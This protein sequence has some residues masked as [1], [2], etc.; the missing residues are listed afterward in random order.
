MKYQKFFCQCLPPSSKS[1]AFLLFFMRHTITF[2]NGPPRL[3]ICHQMA[4]HKRT[5]M[6]AHCNLK[7]NTWLCSKQSSFFSFYALPSGGKSKDAVVH[8]AFVMERIGIVYFQPCVSINKI[9]MGNVQLSHY[10]SFG[11]IAIRT[12]N[13]ETL[14]ILS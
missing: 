5:T 1:I 10:S 2:N 13:F 3:S 4:V 14:S 8:Y 12:L 6:P 9:S 11:N 7:Q